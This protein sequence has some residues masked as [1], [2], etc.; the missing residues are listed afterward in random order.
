MFIISS[1]AAT[2]VRYPL[3][4][5]VGAIGPR[6]A[7]RLELYEFEACPFCRKV[8]EALTML[9]LDVLVRPTPR[10]GDAISRRGDR[11]RRQC[12]MFPLLV[13][14]DV[15]AL[16]YESDAIVTHLYT[17]YGAGALPASA[18]GSA[19]SATSPLRQ[20]RRCSA[21][22]PRIAPDER[23]SRQRRATPL[24]LWSFESSPYCRRVREE[25]C[26]L[27]LPYVLHNLGKGAAG[28]ADFRTRTGKIQV[29][30]LEDP[31]TGTKMFES[32]DIVRYLGAT[33]GA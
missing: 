20:P 4:L 10:G 22:R 31:N 16:L 11:A 17:R 13:D 3:G 23:P 24:E 29:P 19:R 15:D 5:T 28:R 14:P 7:K 8:R 21:R 1:T 30:Y 27:E 9:D 26:E 33:Y 2:L 12:R 6:P 18:Y 25:M 32:R